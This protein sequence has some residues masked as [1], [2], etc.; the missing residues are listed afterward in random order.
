MR[1]EILS[2][3]DEVR[4]G[5]VVDTN[6]AFIAETLETIGITVARH[7]CVG[8]D[9]DDIAAALREIASRS[10]MAVVTGGLGPT[11]DDKTA[12]AAA[13]AAGVVLEE[14]PVA[15]EQI[16]RTL[17]WYKARMMGWEDEASNFGDFRSAFMALVDE[18]G[19]VDHYG[20]PPD[21]DHRQGRGLGTGQEVGGNARGGPG[22]QSGEGRAVHKGD[23][24]AGLARQLEDLGDLVGDRDAQLPFAVGQRPDQTARRDF[25]QFVGRLDPQPHQ[26]ARVAA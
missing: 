15:L 10:D 26:G 3:G 25:G 18:N 24:R 12:E 4:T 5:A 13:R 21:T 14:M 7:T 23:G 6:A 20:L 9:L 22:A 19:N 8:D 1:A 17:E 16:E 2:T 11:A